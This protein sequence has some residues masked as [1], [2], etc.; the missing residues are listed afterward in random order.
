MQVRTMAVEQWLRDLELAPRT[1]VHIRNLMH[2]LFECA[3]RWEMI[4]QNPITRVRQGGS[5]LADPE[6]L[7]PA[8]F[9]SLLSEIKD[10]PYRTMVIL[11]GCLGLSRSEIVGLKWGDF[12]WAKKTLTVQRGVVHC[13]VAR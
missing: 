11:A 4:D 8:E 1:R 13:R 2:V 3:A 9:K 10:E 12:D 7:T 6:V 5:R